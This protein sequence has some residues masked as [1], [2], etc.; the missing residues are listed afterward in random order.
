VE[1]NNSRLEETL[2]GALEG[3]KD[4]KSFGSN[5]NRDKVRREESIHFK[6][7]LEIL[8]ISFKILWEV[9]EIE[10]NKLSMNHKEEKT[11]H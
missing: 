8:R 10:G 4:S 6:I 11:S 1:T 2:L 5:S 3:F 9:E 7:Y